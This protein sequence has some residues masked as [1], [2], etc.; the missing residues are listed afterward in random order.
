MAAVKERQT[1]VRELTAVKEATFT[2]SFRDDAVIE[3]EEW[4]ETQA[5]HPSQDRHGT[6]E[7]GP[8]KT[9]PPGMS[10]EER[11]LITRKSSQIDCSDPEGKYKNDSYS[12]HDMRADELRKR[13]SQF[14]D[15]LIRPVHMVELDEKR[16]YSRSS[17]WGKDLDVGQRGPNALENSHTGRFSQSR[18]KSFLERRKSS[19]SFAAGRKKSSL[20]NAV[21]FNRTSILTEVSNLSIK[22]SSPVFNLIAAM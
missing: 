2:K 1:S 17:L 14:R 8:M 3:I 13:G 21:A 16:R 7:P 4:K 10:K 18:T 22:W 9:R 6:L 5:V 20:I 19:V 12:S 15:L 11:R